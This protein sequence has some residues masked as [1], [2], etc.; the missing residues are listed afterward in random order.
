MTERTAE[1][2]LVG[3]EWLLSRLLD[4]FR[5]PSGFGVVLLG[6]AGVGKTA[7]A[8]AF[9][10]ELDPSTTVL[11]VTGSAVLTDVQ[12]GALSAYLYGLPPEDLVRP[13]A[14]MRRL[15]QHLSGTAPSGAE[16]PLLLVDDAHDLDAGTVG[17]LAQLVGGR[18]VRA[19]ILTRSVPGLPPGFEE[20]ASDGLLD[21]LVVKPLA[22][23]EVERLCSALLGGP[24]VAAAAEIVTNITGGNPMFV[25]MI[26][27]DGM[28]R[29]YLRERNGVW[30]LAPD[31][32]AIGPQVTDLVHAALGLLRPS[33][34]EALEFLALAEPAPATLVQHQVGGAVL[35]NLLEAS[36]VR[37]TAEGLLVLGHPLYGEALR[38][39]A[40]AARRITL[41]RQI[42][43]VTPAPRDADELLRYTSLALHTGAE[44]DDEELLAAARLANRLHDGDFAL[45]AIHAIATPRLRSE[46][47]V[48]TAWAEANN[49]RLEEARELVEEA[50][51]A[52]PGPQVARDATI[53]SLILRARSSCPGDAMH[54]DI[55]RWVDSFRTARD[56]S[57]EWAG[58]A[59]TLLGVTVA[60]NVV[61]LLSDTGAF[62]VDAVRAVSADRTATPQTTVAA[63]LVLAVHLLGAG[64]LTEA[65]TMAA[66]A[67]ELVPTDP[68]TIT[69][70][71]HVA[72]LQIMALL[73]AGEWENA[74]SAFFAFYRRDTRSILRFSGWLDLLEGVRAL[75]EGRFR[76]AQNRL[77]LATEG[78]RNADHLHILPWVCSLAAY[79]ALLSGDV[80]KA[81]VLLELTTAPATTGSRL[82][83]ML[84][85]VYNVTVT[86][87]LAA[88]PEGPAQLRRLAAEAEDAGLL[89]V[90][91][92]ALD[93]ALVLG[94]QSVFGWLTTL[95]A[96]FEGK[97]QK[98]L[99]A[100][101]QAGAASSAEALVEAGDAALSAGYRPL[102]AGCY[103]RAREVFDKRRNAAAARAAQRKLAMASAGM[104][105]AANPRAIQLP[106]AVRLTPSELTIVNLAL[107]GLTNKDI[108]ERQGT[109]VRTV[110]GHLYRI[111]GKFGITRREEL[112]LFMQEL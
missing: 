31:P 42:L 24:M 35:A 97:E 86:A 103:E 99:H 104:D 64:R 91:A 96:T 111:F 13:V 21:S 50:F 106:A 58:E 60:R 48:E 15:V 59:A 52:A 95:T 51:A 110:E 2:Q 84:G 20:L 71:D 101:A 27:R 45:R 39:T 54:A 40:P 76:L 93:Q 53:L 11:P 102:A 25:R 47:L 83:R 73:A 38:R 4:E 69:F 10:A 49:N 3:R 32:P 61:P 36:W 43:A 109:S 94:D 7:V 107:E 65:A 62:D 68:G 74:R 30:H 16:L 28:D 108:A 56:D 100:F 88:D 82:A 22:L 63:L 46:R 92:I 26:V 66:R 70:R 77:L 105:G 33:E 29:G 19:L 57:A 8:D 1:V 78:L 18:K 87:V 89:L 37:K 12:F 85:E 90:A 17:L 80:K 55:D 72:G 44:I 5:G 34:K 98:L 67:T 41:Q 112:R 14:V 75:R 81:R 79:A 9:V 6:E 23:A